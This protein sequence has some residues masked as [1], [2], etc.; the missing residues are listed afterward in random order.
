MRIVL[1]FFLVLLWLR[2]VVEVIGLDGTASL[3]SA[4]RLVNYKEYSGYGPRKIPM[5]KIG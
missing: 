5:L 1:F 3:A 2:K 4:A